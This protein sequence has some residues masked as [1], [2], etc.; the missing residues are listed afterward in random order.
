MDQ[1]SSS[2]VI[3]IIV[4]GVIGTAIGYY[5]WK[6]QQSAKEPM[7]ILYNSIGGEAAIDKLVLVFLTDFIMHDDVINEFFKKLNL[8]RQIKMQKVFLKHVLQQI[9]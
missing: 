6:K 5:F 2:I 3:A 7:A 1:N 4:V 8:E 9:M